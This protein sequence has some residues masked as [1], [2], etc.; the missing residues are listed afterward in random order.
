VSPARLSEEV[1][2]R[3]PDLAGEFGKTATSRLFIRTAIIILFRTI[4]TIITGLTTGLIM[5]PGKI[6]TEYR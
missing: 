5:I 1:D 6:A 3:E 2:R 4:V